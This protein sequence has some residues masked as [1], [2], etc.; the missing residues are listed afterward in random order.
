MNIWNKI[1]KKNIYRPLRESDFSQS[2]FQPFARTSL[3]LEQE[4]EHFSINSFLNSPHIYYS[5]IRYLVFANTTM[6]QFVESMVSSVNTGFDIIVDSNHNSPHFI[7]MVKQSVENYLKRCSGNNNINLY[8]ERLIR[9]M[10]IYGCLS[11]YNVLD[12]K[13]SMIYKTLGVPTYTV[14]REWNENILN[15]QSY[16]LDQNREKHYLDPLY[17]NYTPL[18]DFEGGYAIPPLLRAVFQAILSLKIDDSFVSFIDMFGTLGFIYLT[19][20]NPNA[21]AQKKSDGTLEKP[22]ETALRLQM[23]FEQFVN[24]FKKDRESGVIINRINLEKDTGLKASDVVDFNHVGLPGGSS[25]SSGVEFITETNRKNMMDGINTSELFLG[26]IPKN[27]N[28]SVGE[29]LRREDYKKV[30]PRQLTLGEFL[31]NNI[32]LN[33]MLEKIPAKVTI[34]WKETDILGEIDKQEALLKEEQRKKQQIENVM[35]MLEKKIIT[36][37]EAK[38]VLKPLYDFDKKPATIIR[39][40]K[41]NLEIMGMA[42]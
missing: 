1:F 28:K 29:L 12:S 25:S 41:N 20:I 21:G 26:N 6:G 2:A 3:S 13:E 18:M 30:R 9:R 36:E 39:F 15:Y 42:A 33:L 7:E 4:K 5:L 35:A 40:S 32:N 34:Q 10:E 31:S 23:E 8:I 37:A 22:H 24:Q 38:L 19:L 16:Q 17:F 27:I 14:F 11:E